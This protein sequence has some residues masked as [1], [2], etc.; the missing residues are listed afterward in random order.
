MPLRLLHLRLPRGESLL[1]W[2]EGAQ[3]I[4]HLMLADVELILLPLILL[5]CSR[6]TLE[7]GSR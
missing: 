5:C 1:V 2:G 6:D 4:R 7:Y 3:H